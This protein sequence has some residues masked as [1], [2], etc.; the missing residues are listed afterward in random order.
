MAEPERPPGGGGAGGEGLGRSRGGLTTKLHLSA[1]SRCVPQSLII[2]AGQR[3]DC[4]EFKPVLEKIRVPRPGLGRPRRKP[5]SH[6]ADEAYSN[7]PCREYLWRRSIGHTIPE[8][9]DQKQHRRNRGRRGGRPTGFD[10]DT[11]R[12]RNTVELCFNQ[13][14][15]FRSIATRYEK[16]AISY[17]AA[18][19]LASLLLWAGSACR[20]TLTRS[21]TVGGETLGPRSQIMVS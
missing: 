11:Y 4:T 6:A 14:R 12:R 3:A 21:C 15:G 8:K 18:V 19:T 10:R 13:L 1:D 9:N 2:T 20:R 5:N 17:E 7:G 16:T